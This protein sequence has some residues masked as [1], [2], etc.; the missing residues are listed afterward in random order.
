MA[1]LTVQ[2]IT[3]ASDGLEPTYAAAAGG[4]DTV[5]VVSNLFLHVKNGDASP[6][7]VT[8]VTPGT[9]AGL[10]IADLTA[11]IPA[12]EERMIG[13]IDQNFRATNGLAS[14]TYD[15]VTSVTIA[16]IRV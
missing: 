11:T 14:I 13:P 7:T 2:T 15:G 10:A 4:G 5:Q 3:R 16:A 6:H 1:E 12:S 8:V 9:V